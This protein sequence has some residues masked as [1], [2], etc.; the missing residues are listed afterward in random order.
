VFLLDYKFLE[1]E[2]I[3]LFLNLYSSK[4]IDKD[5]IYYTLLSDLRSAFSDDIEIII[6]WQI[7]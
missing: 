3:I 6:Q 1:Q 7:N 4:D 2:K 5:D